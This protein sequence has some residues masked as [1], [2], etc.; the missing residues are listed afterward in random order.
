MCYAR[1][2]KAKLTVCVAESRPIMTYFADY[3]SC[4]AG[5]HR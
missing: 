4:E 1:T 5:L 2:A 3:A